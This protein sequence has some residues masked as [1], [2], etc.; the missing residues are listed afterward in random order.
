MRAALPFVSRRALLV[1]AL[2]L[3]ACGGGSG[4]EPAGPGPT[5]GALAADFSLPDVNAAS[6]TGG[7]QVS[8]RQRLGSASA[9]YFAHAT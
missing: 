5:V 9:W 2:L 6:P 8:P 3:A 4:F 7:T 1:A